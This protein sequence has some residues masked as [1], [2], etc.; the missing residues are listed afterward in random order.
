MALAPTHAVLGNNDHEL[1]GTLGET[2]VLELG[3][4]EVALV[5]DSGART[6]RAARLRRRF[7]S[8]DLV[9]FG[10]SHVPCDEVGVDGQLLFNP[11]SPTQRRSQPVATFGELELA[12]GSVRHRAIRPVG[13]PKR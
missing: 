7:P 9:V 10:H 3:G 6:G 5:H 11:G 1:R 2:L 13:P 4:V 8:A 12:G